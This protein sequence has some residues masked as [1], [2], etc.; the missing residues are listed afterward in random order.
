MDAFEIY[1][2]LE[3]RQNPEKIRTEGPFPCTRNDAWLGK[4][5]YFWESFIENARWWGE[6]SYKN[7]YVI[8]QAIY[9]NDEEECFNLIDNYN[10]IRSYIKATE[11]ME[12]KGLYVEHV[13]TVSRVIQF[14]RDIRIFSYNA[15][16]A[17]AENCKSCKSKFSRTTIFSQNSRCYLDALPPIQVCFYT[18][19]SPLDLSNYKIVYPKDYVE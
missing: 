1:Q 13:T 11:L 7:G 14:L 16:R 9:I 12:E 2:T 5:Y 17:K 3:D 4:G 6:N 10:H 15:A 19:K 8:S 18:K